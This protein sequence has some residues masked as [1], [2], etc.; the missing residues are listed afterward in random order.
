VHIV[1]HWASEV[2][3]AELLELLGTPERAPDWCPRTL[4]SVVPE[5]SCRGRLHATTRGLLPYRLRLDCLLRRQTEKAGRISLRLEGDLR[6][7]GSATWR[8]AP[9]GGVGIT[10]E[11]CAGV[12]RQLVRVF[13]LLLP[14]LCRVNHRY[15]VLTTARAAVA[16]VRRRRSLSH[17]G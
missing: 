7:R 9:G 8:E 13:L 11:L 14:A 5:S 6:G 1:T 15:V 4:E 17:A 16:E 3:S 2:S 12:Q 10:L